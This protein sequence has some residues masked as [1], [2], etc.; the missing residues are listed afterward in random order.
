[1]TKLDIDTAL[2]WRGRNVVDR[3]GNKIGTFQELYL[4]DA[5]RPAWAA[6]RT[7]LFGMRQTFVPLAAAQPAGDDLQVPFDKDQVKDA[8][9]VDPDE[10]LSSDEE[11]ALYRHY[12]MD[13]PGGTV[14]GAA[15]G[16]SG[17]GAGDAGSRAAAAPAATGA[18]TGDATTRA[19]TG[20][21]ET[22]GAADGGGMRAPG[23]GTATG[24]AVED[25]AA[26]ARAEDARERE[27]GG[28][29]VAVDDDAGDAGRRPTGEGA[30]MVRSE[31]EVSVGT[32]RRVSGKAR[33]RKYVVTEHV[34]KT[35]PVKKEKVAVE[36]D[37]PDDDHEVVAEQGDVPPRS[38]PD[39]R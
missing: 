8:P 24:D 25:R 22:R 17:A 31:E 37:P 32:R 36:M 20:D 35:V 26:R 21:A 33:L 7:G 30:E 23:G 19:E 10:Q 5:D 34:Q 16:E 11:A 6:V 4:D 18:D 29:P 15:G 27:R 12:G 1:M 28:E 13:A 39:T 3:D 2:E 9:N 38:D 14:S